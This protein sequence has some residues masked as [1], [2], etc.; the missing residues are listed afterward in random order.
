L[1]ILQKNISKITIMKN[2]IKLLLL[3]TLLII[4]HAIHAAENIA[5]KRKGN[6]SFLETCVRPLASKV[7]A[8]HC[9]YTIFLMMSL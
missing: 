6:Y 8:H 3:I 2:L 4:T 9:N 5:E 7:E 1:S